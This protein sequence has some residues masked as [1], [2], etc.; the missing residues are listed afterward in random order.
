MKKIL[1]PLVTA[2]GFTAGCYTQG[3]VGMSAT[4][5]SGGG[6]YAAC[7]ADEIWASP[8]TITGS[9]GIFYGKVDVGPLAARF[10]VGIETE[11]RGAHA[12]ADSIFRPFTDEERAAFV[13]RGWVRASLGAQILRAETAG[14]AGLAVL[15]AA[16]A[17]NSQA[18]K[19]NGSK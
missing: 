8:S 7:G 12:G 9:I 17:S 16:W 11:K 4:Y 1:L 3:D 2:L 5:S 10:G 13:E 18:E 6:Y 14:I 19:V 15:Q